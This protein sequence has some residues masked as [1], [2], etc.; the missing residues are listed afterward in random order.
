[1]WPRPNK[2]AIGITAAEL[3][4]TIRPMSATQLVKYFSWAPRS[5]WLRARKRDSPN[6]ATDMKTDVMVMTASA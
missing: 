2:T 3:T 5:F 4:R 6:G 1:M